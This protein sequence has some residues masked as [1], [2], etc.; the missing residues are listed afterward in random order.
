MKIKNYSFKD[1]KL[2]ER[3][4]THSSFSKDN[5]QKLE[6]LGDSILDFVVGEYFFKN[7]DGKEGELTKL[8]SRFVSEDY[9]CKVFDSLE[10]SKHAIVGKSFKGELTDAIKAD[11]VESVIG[12]IYLDS[13]FETVKSIVLDILRLENYKQVEDNDFKTQ[14]QELMQA[15]GKVVE[16]KVLS[17]SGENHDPTF[18]IGA[19]VDGECLAKASASSKQKAENISAQ[20]ALNNLKNR[21]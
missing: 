19:F 1:E 18:E 6:F 14:F 16:Y 20:R 9:L 11:M 17:R 10:L 15:K 7:A 12:A 3:A 13:D 5:Y 21:S 4:M 8:R 2:F